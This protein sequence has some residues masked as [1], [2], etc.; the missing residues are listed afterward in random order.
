MT[1]AL[2]VVSKGTLAGFIHS[3]AEQVDME[4]YVQELLNGRVMHVDETP[5]KTSER[6]DAPGKLETAKIPHLVPISGHTATKGQ[7]C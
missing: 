5:V 4:G 3:A 2:V 6:P 1:H 7:L